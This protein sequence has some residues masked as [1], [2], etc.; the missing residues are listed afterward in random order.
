MKE[1]MKNYYTNTRPE[2]A[3][4]LPQDLNGAKILEI[5][6]GAGLFKNNITSNCEYWGIEPDTAIANQAS[7]VLNKV[8][9]G[10]FKSVYKQL[11]EAYFDCVIC[12]D[13]IEHMEDENEFLQMIK[14]NIKPGAVL[15]GSIPNV[16]YIN[17]LMNLIIFKDWEYADA[18]VLDRTH[19]R[20]FT[21]KSLI[22]TFERNG[23]RVEEFG[24]LNAIRI[25]REKV[26]FFLRGLR[27]LLISHLI[28]ADTKYQQFGFRICQ[29]HDKTGNLRPANR[30]PGSFEPPSHLS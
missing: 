6:C 1:I 28:G 23:Y 25:S 21:E 7:T 27:T 10:T 16:R 17:N 29:T 22:R 8:L 13:V 26:R 12:N 24:G 4:F 19:L 30:A 3:G 20:F 11:P 2:V 15:V 14:T 18:G 9:T 5:G